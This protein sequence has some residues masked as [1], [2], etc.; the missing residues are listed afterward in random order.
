MQPLR[1][2]RRSR[3]LTFL[4]LS[5]LTGIPARALAEAEYGL[6]RLSQSERETLALVLGLRPT[7]LTGAHAALAA[8]PIIRWGVSL[9]PQ[10]RLPLPA[11]LSSPREAPAA[12]ADNALP[13]AAGALIGLTIN[14][15]ADDAAAIW[16][17]T[18]ALLASHAAHSAEAVAPA[19]LS[20]PPPAATPLPQPPPGPTFALTPAGPLGCPVQP[21]AGRVVLTQGYG[22]GSHAPAATWGAVDLAVDGDDDGYAEPGA[23]WYA[24]VVATHDGTVRVTPD[25][26]P[27]GNHIWVSEPGG[28]WR[29]GY[30]HL[31]IITVVSGQFVRAGEQIGMIGSSGASSGPHLD[32][33]L[34]QGDTN[35]DPTWLV[36][37]G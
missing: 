25:S 37:C 27:A 33:Q 29:T 17:R 14:P 9:G 1:T 16:Q 26:Y 28:V 7:E 8:R 3:E 6:R 15:A 31:A 5:S 13:R 18:L 2:L 24:S 10:H 30:S 36:G 11:A 35:I 22:V 20:G 19:L 34:W 23:S 12:L 4:D 21:A 32:Y